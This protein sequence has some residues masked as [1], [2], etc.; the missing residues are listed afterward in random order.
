MGDIEQQRPQRHNNTNGTKVV[1]NRNESL[2][3]DIQNGDEISLNGDAENIISRADELSE[4]IESVRKIVHSFIQSADNAVKGKEIGQSPFLPGT[5]RVAILDP[6]SPATLQDI[7]KLQLPE[8]SITKDDLFGLIQQIFQYSVNTW[9]QGFVDKLYHS[10]DAIGVVAEMILAVLN[11]NVHVFQTSPVLT[12]I[13]KKTGRGLAHLFGLNGPHAGGI[14]QP[15]GSASNMSAIII[16]RNHLFPEIKTDGYGDRKLVIF[17]S[18]DSHYSIEKA[19]Q[20]CGFGSKAVVKVP[21]DSAGCMIVGELQNA[22][23]SARIDGFTPFF[24]NATAGTTVLG[25]FDPL[26]EISNICKKENLWMHVDGSY[27][28]GFVFSE[29]LS[30]GR[31][32]G[33]ELADTITMNPHKMLGAP[34]TTSFLLYKDERE[35][36]GA[37]TLPAGYLFH[38]N[39]EGEVWDLADLT[40]QCGRRGD[41]LKMFLGWNFYGRQ[42][43][44]KM[45]ENAY[46]VAQHL[47][48]LLEN[49]P[50]IILVSRQPL[51]AL[52]VSFY[53]ARNRQLGQDAAKNTQVTR[54]IAAALIKRGFMTDYA[55]AA[56][57]KHLRVVIGRQTRLVTVEGLVK[58]IE[59]VAN[60]LDL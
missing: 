2:K 42:G 7:L 12:L 31:L 3:N 23:D 21:V 18:E 53:W 55:P 5:K 39:D 28:G 30:K 24:V 43:Y 22:I 48:G 57:G 16:A 1:L 41:S 46:S 19:A 56:Y 9:D 27:G 50:D 47:Y 59:G 35:V 58:A 6:H 49:H 26:P 29:T 14:T 15:G 34:V 20:I 45:I 54:S 17:T 44:A 52:Q 11:T 51:P 40:P 60:E 4:L 33:A 25:S 13:E 37:M 8:K 38:N 10:T 36:H 32:D